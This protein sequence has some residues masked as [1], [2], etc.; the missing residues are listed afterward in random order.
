MQAATQRSIPRVTVSDAMHSLSVINW[1]IE[2][3]ITDLQ[4]EHVYGHFEA[5]DIFGHGQIDLTLVVAAAAVTSPQCG[6]VAV[7]YVLQVVGSMVSVLD[8]RRFELLGV[9]H[10]HIGRPSRVD[11]CGQSLQK[12]GL[13][14]LF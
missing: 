3:I 8:N 7:L 10:T 4:S 11:G 14:L 6:A 2:S 13:G 9:V 12:E 5:F 1:G